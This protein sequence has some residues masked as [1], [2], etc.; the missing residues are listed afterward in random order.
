MTRHQWNDQQGT[1]LPDSAIDFLPQSRLRELQLQ[2]LKAIT[3]HSYQH[4]PL[5]RQ[6]MDASGVTP[7]AIQRLEDIRL[8]PLSSKQDLRDSY[9]Y[10]LFAV[11]MSEVVRLH[12][13]S[14]TTGKPIV[15]GYTA[16][17]MEIWS[18]VV[19]RT[20]HAAGFHRGDVVQNCYGYGLFT[21]GLGLHGGLESLGATVIPISGGNS[22]RQL[23]VMKDFH[24]TAICATPSYFI[25][26]M[27]VASRMGLDF[28]R[29]LQI[30]RGVFG[31]EPW[32]DGMRHYIQEQTGIEAYDIYGLSEIIGPGVGAECHCR[33]G[34]H[35]FEDHFLVE[36]LDPDSLQPVADGQEGELVI[37]TLSK[38][39]MP[40][41]RY[42]TRDI[43]AIEPAPCACGRT[44]RRIKRISRRS[45]D[46]LIIRG[47]NLFPGQIETALLKAA[48]DLP[49]YQIVLTRHSGLDRICVQ[50]EQAAGMTAEAG[51]PLSQRIA[52]ALEQITG[53]HMEVALVAA[54]SLP[55]SEGKARRLLDRRAES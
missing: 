29:D 44:L 4:V 36:I 25:H 22:E 7:E 17:D 3:A 10:G 41:L 43:S 32:S 24:V 55:R 20:L 5:F 35:I 46:M 1:F 27:E 34:L 18:Q 50:V 21:G 19:R 48:P 13:S 45:D 6:R 31:A 33:N 14:G 42:R 54:G 16:A 30:K 52:Q 28:K 12:A 51:H 39:A 49:H 2:R 11:P 15:V 26:L 37:S 38:Q 9:P 23:M 40:L 47:V 8:L 53:L